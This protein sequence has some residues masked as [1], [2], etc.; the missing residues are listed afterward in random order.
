MKITYKVP[1][2]F[3]A[4]LKQDAYYGN[5]MTDTYSVTDLL[6]EPRPVILKKRHGDK[7]KPEIEDR[8]WAFFGTAFHNA[9]EAAETKDDL[10]EQLVKFGRLRGKFDHYDSKTK[11]LYDFKFSSVWTMIY[12]DGF[13]E[14]H[15]QLSLYSYMLKNIGYDVA[16]CKI[17]L[18]FR[19]WKRTEYERGKYDIPK[20]YV[21][22]DFGKPLTEIDG[23]ELSKW[24]DH[25]ISVFDGYNDTPDDK[26]PFCTEDY[27]WAKPDTYAVMK[28]QNKRAV[29]VFEDKEQADIFAADSQAYWVD[30]RPGDKFK[31]C[32]YCDVKEFCNQFKNKDHGTNKA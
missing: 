20:P 7:L 24:I 27:R 19:D 16:D 11:T 10:I 3:E 1:E 14:F 2:K 28:A 29:R 25:T 26:L 15:K 18:I 32:D 8:L 17:I 6:K 30:I 5:K 21:T 23:V 12:N 9:M 22:I 13:K 31:R 4:V